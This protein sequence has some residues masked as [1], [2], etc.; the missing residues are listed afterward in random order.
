MEVRCKTVGK[1]GERIGELVEHDSGFE[2]FD[3]YMWGVPPFAKV[4]VWQKRPNSW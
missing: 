3:Q 2:E 4:F 1:L